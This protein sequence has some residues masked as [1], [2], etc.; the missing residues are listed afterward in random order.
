MNT[1]RN[2][3]IFIFSAL[4]ILLV[5]LLILSFERLVITQMY[6]QIGEEIRNEINLY[7]TALRD[8]DENSFQDFISHTRDLISKMGYSIYFVSKNNRILINING[9]EENYLVKPDAFKLVSSQSSG[10]FFYEVIKSKESGERLFVVRKRVSDFQNNH[11]LKEVN[12]I[13]FI[14]NLNRL[15][16]FSKDLRTQI[17]LYGLLIFILGLLAIRY[18][19]RIF[20]DP[21]VQ[22]I[23]YLKDYRQN[24][25]TKKLE[26]NRKDEFKFLADS[27]NQLIEKIEEDF[28]ALR[29]LEKYR[30]E[31][32]GNVSH[33]LRTPLFTIQSLLETLTEGAIDDP[34]VNKTYLIKAQENLER[35]NRLLND[36]IDISYIESKKLRMSFRYFEIRG[37]IGKVVED[38]RLLANQKKINLQFIPDDSIIE[39]AFGDKERL[40]QVLYNL[41]DNAIRHNPEG[42]NVKIYFM[43]VDSK[44]RIFVEDNGIGIPEEDLPRIFERFYRVNKERSREAGGT[45]LGLAIAKHIVEAHESK[46]FVESQVNKGTKFYFDLNCA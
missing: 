7:E 36:L 10:R 20:S 16:K 4:S 13:V 43:K 42:T 46:I 6:K 2:K 25:Y 31:F 18:L 15:D 3:I 30:S 44:I 38:L 27:I 9:E 32:L 12:Q 17:L 28:N 40:Y 14:S 39:L 24:G 34:A 26:L 8:I 41:I 35:L 33:E 5:G 45:G 22:F 37:L 21:I 23:E 11:Y 19:S 1:F 29:K